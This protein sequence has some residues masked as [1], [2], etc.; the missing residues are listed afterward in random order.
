MAR[1]SISS[2]IR[3]VA[4]TS[5]P[6]PKRRLGKNGPEVT[7]LGLGG[8]ALIGLRGKENDAEAQ[9]LV[10]R[11]IEMGINYF[12]TASTYGP[13]EAR[14][15]AV[16]GQNRPQIVLATKTSDR[17]RDG[18]WRDLEASL[19]A[20]RTD[21]LDLWQVHRIDHMDEVKKV[22]GKKGAMEAFEEAK[23]QGIVRMIG[24]TGHYDPI[25]LG[26]LVKRSDFDTVLIPANAA[27]IHGPHSFTKKVL[28]LATE[29][30]MGVVCMKVACAGRIF[31]PANLRKMRDALYYCLSLP[32]STAIVGV[33]DEEQLIE[34]VALAKAFEGLRKPEMRR[35]SDLTKDYAHIACFFKKGNE[36]HNPFWKPYGWKSKKTAA[37]EKKLIILRGISGTGKSTLA[38]SLEAKYKTKALSSDDFFMDENK[39][40]FDP[41]KLT[42]A[43]AWNQ[44]RVKDAMKEGKPVIIVDNTNTMGWMMRPYVEAARQHG[45]KVEFMEPSWSPHLKDESGKWDVDFIEKLQK[46]KERSDIGKVVP[47]NV[48]ER[49]RDKYEYGVT[50]EDVLKSQIPEGMAR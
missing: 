28:P 40:K 50:E 38:K 1:H 31:S 43:H 24:V 35:I 48:L 41:A 7:I 44:Q 19:K 3:E 13:S 8:G 5:G 20:L 23:E 2:Y 15:G 14:I 27:D 36:A 32:I 6:I 26:S 18:A 37:E 16:I 21:Y 22:I 49:M 17:T 10:Q 30:K 45:Y 34:D 4:A 42:E 9:D 47:R 12:D 29:R 11:A 39:Y 46:S 25:P 33:D